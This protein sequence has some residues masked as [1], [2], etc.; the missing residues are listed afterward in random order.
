MTRDPASTKVLDLVEFVHDEAYVTAPQVAKAFGITCVEAEDILKHLPFDS[1][2]GIGVFSIPSKPSAD[3]SAA[4]KG[5]EWDL[6]AFL[7]TVTDPDQTLED[8]LIEVRGDEPSFESAVLEG[9]AD[10]RRIL[11]DVQARVASF[12]SP[13][14]NK[15]RRRRRKRGELLQVKPDDSEELAQM[16]RDAAEA[17]EKAKQA[18]KKDSVYQVWYQRIVSQEE[19]EGVGKFAEPVLEPPSPAPAKGRPGTPAPT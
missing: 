15:P 14:S 17:I 12:E 8:L 5:R 18:G 13:G 9:M 3:W 2:E 16:R 1:G 6:D 7:G 10:L 4:S 19:Q 11:E